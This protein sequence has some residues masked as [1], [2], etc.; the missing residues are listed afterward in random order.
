MQLDNLYV[1]AHEDLV[2]AARFFHEKDWAFNRGF[3]DNFY[4]VMEDILRGEGTNTEF[5]PLDVR[6]PRER[7]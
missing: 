2:L 7:A 6:R 1:L 5:N 3:I 4:D